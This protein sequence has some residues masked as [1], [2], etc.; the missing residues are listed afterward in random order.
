MTKP[1]HYIMKATLTTIKEDDLYYPAC[2]CKLGE[3]QCNEK[4]TK[5]TDETWTCTKCNVSHSE[6]DYRY[7]LQMKI[8]DHI[9]TMWAIAF[10]EVS[11]QLLDVT[12]KELYSIDSSREDGNYARQVIRD[13]LNKDF[14]KA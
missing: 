3:R 4:L 11:T 2:P 14:F 7:L 6:Y 5:E 12:T 8:E 9:D 1:L 10:D 13:P